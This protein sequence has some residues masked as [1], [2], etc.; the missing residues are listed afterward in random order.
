MSRPAYANSDVPY[1]SFAFLPRN[2]RRPSGFFL[3]GPIDRPTG[4]LGDRYDGA[5]TDVIDGL[6]QDIMRF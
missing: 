4:F 3:I 5:D 1:D 2:Q 6:V